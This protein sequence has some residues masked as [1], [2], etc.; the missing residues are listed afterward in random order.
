[1]LF[2][3]ERELGRLVENV[4]RG[5]HTVITGPADI[6]KT[7]LLREAAL[8]LGE[9]NVVQALYVSDAS[10][11]RRLL[12]LA[13]QGLGAGPAAKERRPSRTTRVVLVARECRGRN[14]PHP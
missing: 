1:M 14:A 12:E 5:R 13:V 10:R 9:T 4:M 2:G 6:G 11:P 8:C 7:A 3:R